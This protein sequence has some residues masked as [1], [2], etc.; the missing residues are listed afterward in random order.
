M[1]PEACLILVR[2][3]SSRHHKKGVGFMVK[4]V[5]V[6]ALMVLALSGCDR[7]KSDFVAACESAIKDTLRSPSGYKQIKVDYSTTELNYETYIQ[8]IGKEEAS[9]LY[10]S[11]IESLKSGE[12]NPV[13]LHALVE[14]DA[15][16][17]YGTAV[18]AV[19]RCEYV[20]MSKD[21]KVIAPLIKVNGKTMTDRLADLVREQAGSSK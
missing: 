3:V 2:S 4:I 18:R 9:K 6:A 12:N 19:N 11:Q 17:A 13:V 5:G 15:P 7:T 1:C 10:K 14:F 21:Q 20:L 8:Y 16:N